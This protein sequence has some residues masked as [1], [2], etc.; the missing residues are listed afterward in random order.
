VVDGWTGRERAPATLS[1]GR[2]LFASLA[3]A[4]GLAD[5]V[6][7]EAAAPALETLFVD[8][9]FGSLTR[10]ARARPRGLDR[11]RDGGRT[12]GIVS[13]VADLRE[14]HPGQ[15][16]V[17]KEPRRSRVELSARLTPAPAAGAGPSLRAGARAS[18]GAGMDLLADV[19]GDAGGAAAPRERCG[20]LRTC[21]PASCSAGRRS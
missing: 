17:V 11:L 4:L 21:S 3:L 7:Q 12:V 10:H 2:D 13:H 14:P 16:R 19:L 15:L 8:E 1:G 9:G 6:A 20:Q 18:L 5:V